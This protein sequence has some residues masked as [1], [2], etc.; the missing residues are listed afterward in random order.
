MNPRDYI[1]T[2]DPD[3]RPAP[4]SIPERIVPDVDWYNK[5][6]ASRRKVHTVTGVQGVVIHATAGSTTAG[7]LS[8]WK[9]PGGGRAAAHW[10]I[11]AEREREHGRNIIVPVYESLA[12][13]HVL[14]GKSDP[15][16]NGGKAMINHWTL[17][18]EIVNTMKSKDPYSD[19]QIGMTA[20]LVRYCWAKYPNLKWVFS[21]AAVDPKRRTDPGEEFPWERFVQLVRAGGREKPIRLKALGRDL[22][23]GLPCCDGDD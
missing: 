17:G 1:L 20:Q 6:R 13:W 10:I 11:P 9:Q 14:D 16:V 8:W 5:N 23:E 2:L 3:Q 15:R 22:G 21:H 12:A 19:W 7:A 18:I 4:L